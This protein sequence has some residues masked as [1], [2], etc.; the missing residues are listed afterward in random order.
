M[1]S[2][3]RRIADAH[4]RRELKEYNA[5]L[6][7]ETYEVLGKVGEWLSDALEE[8]INPDF[9]EAIEYYFAGMEDLN[10]FKEYYIGGNDFKLENKKDAELE[11]AVED[12]YFDI[13]RQRREKIEL[14][15]KESPIIRAVELMDKTGDPLVKEVLAGITEAYIKVAVN[16]PDRALLEQ[17]VEALGIYEKAIDNLYRHNEAVRQAVVEYFGVR[18]PQTLSAIKQALG[19]RG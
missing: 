3:G 14:E 16:A 10:S 11:K 13:A 17:A 19:E 2:V 6:L 9:R 18:H 15:E 1:A 7:E 12:L 8:N 4:E 5:C